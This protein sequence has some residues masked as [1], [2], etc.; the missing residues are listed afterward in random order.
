[1]AVALAQL[2]NQR[3]NVFRQLVSESSVVSNQYL[4]HARQFW[5]RLRQLRRKRHWQPARGCHHRSSQRLQQ[6]SAWRR[7]GGIGVFSDNQDSHLI[8]FASFFSFSTSSATD[9]TLM[10]ALR[11]AGASTLMVLTVE[12]VRNAQISRGYSFQRLLLG[13]HDV[14]SDA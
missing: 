9:L 2:G 14:G 7:Q 11:V 4:G 1:M 10:P 13:L 5:R 6:C 12:A 8:T 3:R